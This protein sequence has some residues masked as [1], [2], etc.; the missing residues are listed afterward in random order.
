MKN[1][2]RGK[3]ALL[4]A[5][6]CLCSAVQQPAHIRSRTADAVCHSVTEMIG[7]LPPDPDAETAFSQLCYDA[8]TEKLYRDGNET[9]SDCGIFRAENGEILVR[10]EATLT[11]EQ[12]SAGFSDAA[13][14]PT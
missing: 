11:E 7:K 3:T 9:G 4:A 2:H 14:Y 5:V 6:I 10:A 1:T 8:E 13:E 12:A